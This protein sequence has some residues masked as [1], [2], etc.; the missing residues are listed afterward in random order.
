MLNMHFLIFATMVVLFIKMTCSNTRVFVPIYFLPL[1]FQFIKTDSPIV[2]G[3]RMLSYAPFQS[4][5]AILSSWLIGKT[6]CYVTW[7]SLLDTLYT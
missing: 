6:G 1:Y 5:I 7:L 4:I 2:V 3:V